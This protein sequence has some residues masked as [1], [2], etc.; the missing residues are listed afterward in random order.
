M[1]SLTLSLGSAQLLIL[2]DH[3]NESPCGLGEVGPQTARV[4][5]PPAHL[6]VVP[7]AAVTTPLPSPNMTTFHCTMAA[8]LVQAPTFCPP[9][10]RAS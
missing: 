7:R 4:V 10:C 9:V 1:D 6:T 5:G 3:Q 8:S 2:T